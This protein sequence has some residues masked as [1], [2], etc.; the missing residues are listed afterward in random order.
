[1]SIYS[2]SCTLGRYYSTEPVRT[3]FSQL[4]HIWALQLFSIVLYRIAQT[5]LRWLCKNRL[6]QVQPRILPWTE[7]WALN[8]LLQN[9]NPDGLNSFVCSFVCMLAGKHVFLDKPCRAPAEK[10][11]PQ[12]DSA[13]TLIRNGDGAFGVMCRDQKNL[14]TLDD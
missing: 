11:P 9:I 12:C 8:Q 14:A 13:A 10:H 6:F 2:R 3:G 7:V 5:L 1:M 4:W